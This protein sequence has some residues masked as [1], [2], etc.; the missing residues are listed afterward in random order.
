MET[1]YLTHCENL[2]LPNVEPCVMALGFFDGVHIGHQ[3]VIEMAKQKA[4]EKNVKVAVM[5]FF[6]HPKAVLNEGKEKVNYLTPIEMKQEIFDKLGIDKLYVIQFDIAFAGL[7]PQ[8]FIDQYVTG[9]GAVHV[10]AG[11]DFTYGYLG[12]GNMDTVTVDSRGNFDVTTIP[13]VEYRGQKISSTL[14]RELLSRGEVQTIASLIGDAYE[15]RGEMVHMSRSR[16]RG[17]IVTW[18]A[19]DPYYTL[20][21]NGLYKIEAILDNHIYQGITYICSREDGSVV[22]EM[23]LFDFHQKLHGKT[24]KIKWLKRVSELNFMQRSFHIHH[25]KRMNKMTQ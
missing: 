13:K 17:S 11:F 6:P 8:G 1:V 22:T 16:R 12:R 4:V 24:I 5:T 10:V 18:V 3:R 7:S 21:A 15:T 19:T 20:P 14:I 9:L 25:T 2:S 23:E